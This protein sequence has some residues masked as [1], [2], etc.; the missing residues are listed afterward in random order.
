[1]RSKNPG[2]AE[3]LLTERLC[4]YYS[5]T[6]SSSSGAALSRIS[7]IGPIHKP[8]TKQS[9]DV[10]V[11]KSQPIARTLAPP[12]LVG[13]ATDVAER[14]ADGL[15]DEVMAR[16]RGGDE[17]FATRHDPSA[18]HRA[19]AGPG[20]S[21][22]VGARGGALPGDV[23][24][25][26]ERARGGG[27][28][29]PSHTRD[30][31]GAAMSSDLS[32]VRIHRDDESARLNRM[33]SARAFT[34]GQDI[35]FGSGEYHPET[36]AGEHVLAHELAHTRQQSGV[37]RISRLW[38]LKSKKKLP[39]SAATN[40]RTLK[41]R[42]I[43][44]V[45]DRSQDEVVI[46]PEDQPTGLS[47]LVAGMQRKVA[48]VKSVQQRKLDK[49]EVNSLDN[50]INVYGY[51]G[52]ERTWHVRGE[53]LSDNPGE[54]ALAAPQTKDD[55]EPATIAQD[56]ALARLQKKGNNIVAMSVA[57]GE[58]AMAAAAPV[59]TADKASSARSRMRQ[60]LDN[61]EHVRKLGQMNMVDLFMGN[62][63]RMMSGNLG[64]WFYNPQNAITLIDHVD[65]G[66]NAGAEMTGGMLDN[67]VWEQ[68]VCLQ[69]LKTA[70]KRKD[71]ANE[72]RYRLMMTME[73]PGDGGGADDDTARAW[74]NEVVNGKKRADRIQEELLAGMNDVR[75]KIIKIFASKKVS[76]RKPG[77]W[78]S[79]NRK[80]AAAQE[81][82]KQTADRASAA[83]TG[84]ARYGDDQ[85]DYFGT[86][87]QRATYLAT[88]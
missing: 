79:S 18:I 57:E 10:S 29:L 38:D 74:F 68:R 32:S 62:L 13:D 41:S 23:S 4:E 46:K 7:S 3:L 43:W 50:M 51:P 44:F 59:A 71:A 67:R 19:A 81:S 53:F 11:R 26:I 5:D 78:K 65:P 48:K 42:P 75:D 55:E 64:N 6:L 61:S 36:A 84:D 76:W 86:L 40:V 60:L 12:L 45:S 83:D 34:L 77:S 30:R 17:Q 69:W 63:D 47:D 80:A 82:L 2:H 72:A 54:Q 87:Q 35:F 15:A 25:Q 21:A 14:E 9:S 27:S 28:P 66:D 85:P 49:S 88:H 70:S 37:R 16:L 73:R 33:V 56:D 24:E 31:M 20:P 1:M 52:Q 39:I 22:V 8:R 58:D